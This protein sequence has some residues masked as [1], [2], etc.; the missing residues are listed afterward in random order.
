MIKRAA[1][2]GLR[3]PVDLNRFSILQRVFGGIC[4]V[5]LLLV[6]LSIIYSRTITSIYARAEYVDRTMAEGA[7]VAQFAT[8]VSETKANVTQYAL[9]ESDADLRIA[10]RSLDELNSEIRNMADVFASIGEN[11]DVI[12]NLSRL[13]GRCRDTVTA[14]IQAINMR[15]DNGAKL[16]QS[17]TELSTTVAAIVELLSH[18]ADDTAALDDAIRLMESFHSGVESATRFLA[19]RN[20]ADSDTSRVD[21]QAM[22]GALQALQARNIANPRIHRFMKAMAEPLDRYRKAVAGLIAATNEFARAGADRTAASA[23]LIEATRQIR[24]SAN[25]AQSGTVVGMMT[26]VMSA[27]RLGYVT[28]FLA[29]FAGIFLAI[30]IGKGIARPIRQITAVM[31]ELA[32]GKVDVVIPHLD[33]GNEIGA[34]ADAVRVFR[35]NK[36]KADRLSAENEAQRFSKEERA[37]KLELLNQ[38]FESTAAALTSTLTSAAAGLRHSAESMFGTTEEASQR[39]LS[40]KTAAQQALHNVEIVASA[41]QELSASIDAISDSAS[42]SSSLSTQTCEAADTTNRAVQALAA[43]ASEIERVV[44]LIKDI[45]QQT[46]LLA[47]NATIEAARAGGAGRGFAVVASEVKTLATETARATEEIESQVSRIQSVIGKVVAAI[48]D[49]VTQIVEMNV[50]ASS[51]A[52]AVDQQRGATRTIADSAH[53]ALT[54]AEHAVNAIAS[55]EGAA[56]ATKVEADQVLGAARQL[57]AQSDDLNTEF[58]RFIAGVRAA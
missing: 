28:S 53:Q 13:A 11:K 20:P 37:Q 27:R 32:G 33:R 21:M 54:S 5:L 49:I 16:L 2:N 55:I 8:L 3:S 52:T 46:N 40:G 25:A 38:S 6:A 58:D 29:I 4:V 34:M 22:D 50:I 31:R 30:V 7:A 19:S 26:S 45:A 10:Q 24:K 41:T 23:A 42:R 56:T 1:F 44:S 57:S 51:V 48:Q 9:S 47:L 12:D 43:D 14:T 17:A 15:R 18:D 35:D 39:S 36:I